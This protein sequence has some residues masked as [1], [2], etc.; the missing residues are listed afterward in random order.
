MLGPLLGEAGYPG[1]SCLESPM[2]GVMHTSKLSPQRQSAGMI[3]AAR[4]IA[5]CLDDGVVVCK[6]PNLQ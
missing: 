3:F 2:L 6:D 5:E 4:R 1:D